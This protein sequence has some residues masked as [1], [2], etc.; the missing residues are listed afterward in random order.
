MFPGCWL[1]ARQPKPSP[2]GAEL[3]RWEHLQQAP[4]PLPPRP[5]LL[6]DFKKA[7]SSHLRQER[8]YFGAGLVFLDVH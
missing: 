7:K 3:P 2:S 8:P 5:F 4:A 1:R 6:R